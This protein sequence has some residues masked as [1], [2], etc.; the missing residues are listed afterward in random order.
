MQGKVSF[1]TKTVILQ[2]KTQVR[3]KY[4]INNKTKSIYTLLRSKVEEELIW[5]TLFLF[6]FLDFYTRLFL[7]LPGM[8]TLFS[9]MFYNWI[10]QKLFWSVKW[11]YYVKLCRIQL[12][13]DYEKL[14]SI[15]CEDSINLSILALNMI[16]WLLIMVSWTK[17]KMRNTSIIKML[18]T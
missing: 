1:P 12:S 18:N 6:I 8:K 13:W 14:I 4:W 17:H 11:T 10:V 3:Q 9:A 7:T 16:E 2:P 5:K 15:S